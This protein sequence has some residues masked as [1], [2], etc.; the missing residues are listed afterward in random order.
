MHPYTQC[1]LSAIPIMRGLE[2]PGPD[3]LAP[4]A[5]LDEKV[6]TD[7][8]LFAPRCPFAT[9]RCTAERPVLE[10]VGES[11]QLHACFH[12]TARRVVGVEIA[13]AAV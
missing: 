1:L 6:A 2:E 11:G 7:G 9:E 13:P 8:C 12:P 4:L 10:A 5:P 3:R